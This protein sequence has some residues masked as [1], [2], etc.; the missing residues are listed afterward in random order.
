VILLGDEAV[1]KTSLF[2]RYIH[3]KFE[4]SYRQTLGTEI[5]LKEVS[6]NGITVILQIWDVAGGDY[7][8]R[9]REKFYNGA[10]GALIVFD[11]T[12]EKTYNSIDTWTKEFEKIADENPS[13]ILVGNKSDVGEEIMINKEIIE[14]YTKEYPLE[15]TSAKTG[16]NVEKTFKKLAEMLYEKKIAS[17]N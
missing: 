6:I 12:R 3:N 14:K 16:E 1:G 4:H 5:L 11:T 10:A 7:F 8:S 15:L 17:E 13:Y 2:Y 9:Y